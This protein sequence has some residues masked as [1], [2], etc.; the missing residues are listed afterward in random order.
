ML[1]EVEYTI[2]LRFK[3][4]KHSRLISKS[5]LCIIRFCYLYFSPSNCQLFTNIR[6][7]IVIR[8]CPCRKSCTAISDRSCIDCGGYFHLTSFGSWMNTGHFMTFRT[9]FLWGKPYKENRISE[10]KQRNSL[11]N[12]THIK[13]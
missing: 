2:R 7:C 8:S 3:G 10:L 9:Q 13:F 6:M 11:W 4:L 1:K 12:F 5:G